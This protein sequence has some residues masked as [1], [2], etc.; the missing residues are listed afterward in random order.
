MPALPS[1]ISLDTVMALL[2]IS[3][4]VVIFLMQE[5]ADSKITRIIRTQFRWQS[6]TG[7]LKTYLF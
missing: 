4:G 7:N 2:S 5:R 6:K 1:F 3:I